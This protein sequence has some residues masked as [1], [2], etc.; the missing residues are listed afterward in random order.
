[1]SDNK[2][3]NQDPH[4]RVCDRISLTRKLL[5]ELENGKFLEGHAVDISPR[6]ALMKTAA[7]LEEELLGMA[8]TLFVISD[9]GHFSVGYPCKVARL[10]GRSIGLEIDKKSAAAFGD[11]MTKDLLGQ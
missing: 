4:H 3:T 8:G 9:Q 1:M 6:G 10:K 2:P 7:R 11:Y 5:L